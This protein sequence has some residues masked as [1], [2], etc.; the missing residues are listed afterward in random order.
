P[1]LLAELAQRPEQRRGLRSL[2]ADA[3]ETFAKLLRHAKLQRR[4]LQHHAVQVVVERVIEAAEDV[5]EEPQVG[6]LASFLGAQGRRL[7]HGKPLAQSCGVSLLNLLY[8]NATG[9]AMIQKT[10]SGTANSPRH[11]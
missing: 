5:G 7:I 10:P 9:P 8:R 11:S 4:S 2:L 6:Q 1:Q 3:I